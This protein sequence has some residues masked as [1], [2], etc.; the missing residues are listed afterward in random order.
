MAAALAETES[1]PASR[2]PAIRCVINLFLISVS[3][4][5]RIQRDGGKRGTEMS[6]ERKVLSAGMV[7]SPRLPIP[8][9]Q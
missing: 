8:K 3:S 9:L 2:P 1:H 5:P 6:A 4:I 7:A